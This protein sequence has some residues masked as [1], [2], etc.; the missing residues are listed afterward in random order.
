MHDN[1]LLHNRH[2]LIP[3]PLLLLSQI[4]MTTEQTTGYEKLYFSSL[5]KNKGILRNIFTIPCFWH[6]IQFGTMKTKEAGVRVGGGETLSMT[7][8]V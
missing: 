2:N 8:P 3:Q 6:M 1:I 7:E 5:L 4:K